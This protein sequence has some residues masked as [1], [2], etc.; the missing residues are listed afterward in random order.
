MRLD[1]LLAF[2]AFPQEV[3][4]PVLVPRSER[5][6]LVDR[7]GAQEVVVLEALAH[8]TCAQVPIFEQVEVLPSVWDQVQRILAS[9]GQIQPSALEVEGKCQAWSM[10]E[11]HVPD[12]QMPEGIASREGSWAPSCEASSRLL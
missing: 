10:L 5:A 1:N 2:L 11:Y 9:L 6:R 4:V 3:P 12:M 7:D 8:G